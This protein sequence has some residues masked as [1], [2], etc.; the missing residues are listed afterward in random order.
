VYVVPIQRSEGLDAAQIA[1]N[2]GAAFFVY[3]LTCRV[4]FA[5]LSWGH[6]RQDKLRTKSHS[7]AYVLMRY[8]YTYTL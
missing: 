7:Q 3:M 2:Y 8:T 4:W 6:A 5:G 1:L